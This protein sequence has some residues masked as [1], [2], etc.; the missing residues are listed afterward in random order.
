M[1]IIDLISLAFR[2]T[3]RGRLRSTL[4]ITAVSI[5][6]FA[7]LFIASTGNA[8]V[9][10]VGEQLDSLGI[11]GTLIYPTKVASSSGI[12]LEDEDAVAVM[13]SVSDIQNAM[14]LIVKYGTYK[15]KNWQGNSVIYGIDDSISS[16]LD[17]ELLFGRYPTEREVRSAAKVAVVDS[18]FASKVYGRSNIVGKNISLAINGNYSD[19]E[20]IGIISP[21]STGLSM[22]VG[23]ALPMFVYIPYTSSQAATGQNWVDQLLIS[24]NDEDSA[25][26][27]VEYLSRKYGRSNSFTFE[28]IS[29][30][31]RDIDSALTF[32]SAFLTAIAAVSMVVAGIGIMTT[33]LSSAN[34][35][36]REI[37]V[38]MSIGAH[39]RDIALEF[40][41]ESALISLIGSTIGVVCACLATAF[42]TDQIQINIFPSL[43]AMILTVASAVACG[44]IFGVA[45]AIKASGLDPIDALRE[46]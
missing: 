24:G 41:V 26:G 37:G 2:N 1:K 23:D 16:M 5:G 19:Y 40:I 14:P 15:I 21:Q 43:K 25:V 42:V 17:V 18:D 28:D 20:I 7:T 29:G 8:A 46:N 38:Y 11:S 34:E 6:V 27:A 45:P 33:M 4:V 3:L 9:E 13:A 32:T 12:H 30:L 39:R 35:R 36:R 10:T 44:I 31:R 22:L